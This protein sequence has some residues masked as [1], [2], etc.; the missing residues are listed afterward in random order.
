MHISCVH[1]LHFY[2]TQIISVPTVYVEGLGFEFR[3]GSRLF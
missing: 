3:P 2:D 1:P